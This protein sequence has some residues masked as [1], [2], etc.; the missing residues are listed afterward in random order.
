MAYPFKSLSKMSYLFKLESLL[1]K[2]NYSLKSLSKMSYLFKLESLLSKM[3]FS[4]KQLSKMSYSFKILLKI[5]TRMKQPL[6]RQRVPAGLE[7]T[8]A[9]DYL[10]YI[11]V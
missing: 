2:M 11:I 1:S 9:P 5:N 4:F 7:K 3:S 10:C 8:M 6:Q